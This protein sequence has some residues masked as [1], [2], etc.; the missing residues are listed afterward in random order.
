M[1]AGCVV[2]VLFGE[3]LA[4]HRWPAQNPTPQPCKGAPCTMAVYNVMLPCNSHPTRQCAGEALQGEAWLLTEIF[5]LH[6]L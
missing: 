6:S 2:L 4:L 1:H 3:D 5:C